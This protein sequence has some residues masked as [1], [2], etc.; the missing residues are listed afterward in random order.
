MPVV[1]T[2]EEL[3][4]H[5]K[6]HIEFLISS[7]NAYDNGYKSESKRLAVSIRVLLHDTQQST[8]LLSQLNQ[9][10]GKFVDTATPIEDNNA[11]SHAG[12]IMISATNFGSEYIAPLDKPIMGTKIW[13]PFDTWWN[14]I[15]FIDKQSRKLSRKEII[16]GVANKDGGAHVDPSLDDKYA[17]LSRHNSLGWVQ[18]DGVNDRHIPDPEKA[19]VRQIAH[20]VLKTLIPEYQTISPKPPKDGIIFAD[21]GFFPNSTIEQVKAQSRVNEKRQKQVKIGR[22]AL[23][24]FFRRTLIVS[25]KCTCGHLRPPRSPSLH[26]QTHGLQG[27]CPRLE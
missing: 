14:D 1:Q 26:N 15:V 3:E 17:A 10:N 4:S 12:L 25:D 9:K 2:R 16:L 22:N 18:T 23:E 7:A 20:E 27:V 6:E 8:S 5:L 13:S 19:A 24:R 11:S 21:G